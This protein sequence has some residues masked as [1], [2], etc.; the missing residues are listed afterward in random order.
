ML[1]QGPPVRTLCVATSGVAQ[2]C[3][4]SGVLFVAARWAQSSAA[5]GGLAAAARGWRAHARAI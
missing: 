5:F 1:W 4:S 3:P 2:G